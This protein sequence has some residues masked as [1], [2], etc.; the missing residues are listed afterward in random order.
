MALPH[1]LEGGQTV[2]ATSGLLEVEVGGGLAHVLR[3]LF[4]ELRMVTRQKPLDRRD[5]LL[6]VGLGAG[7]GAHTGTQ[8]HA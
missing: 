2:T 3:Q 4:L 8:A 5:V 1:V 6:V 7:A